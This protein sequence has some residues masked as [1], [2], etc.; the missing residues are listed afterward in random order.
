M[1]RLTISWAA[2]IGPTPGS[3]SSA[4]CEHADVGEDLALEFVGLDCRCLDPAG[5]AAQH[6][7]RGEL[8]GV[9]C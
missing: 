7:P 9:R 5:E 4:G 3:S 6:K 8:V 1:T 2:T